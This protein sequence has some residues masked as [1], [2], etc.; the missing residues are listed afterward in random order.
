MFRKIGKLGKYV[1]KSIGFQRI[2][3]V[4]RWGFWTVV[5]FCG[6]GSIVA[7]TGVKGFIAV[8]I[9]TNSRLID[10]AGDHVVG[11]L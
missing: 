6:P 11:Y 10:Y 3:R 9:I 8:S 5:T 4:A 7:V 2:G 1:F